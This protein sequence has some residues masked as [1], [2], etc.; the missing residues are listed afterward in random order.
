[1]CNISLFSFRL[2]PYKA[3]SSKYQD[4]ERER[5]SK[6]ARKNIEKESEKNEKK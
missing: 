1:M 3:R 2:V 5:K 6:K 4:K